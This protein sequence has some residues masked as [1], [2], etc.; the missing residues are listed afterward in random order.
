MMNLN[1]EAPERQDIEALLP[2]HAAGTLSRRDSDRVEQALA[3]DRELARRYELVR[4]ELNETIH[5]NE[6]LGAPSARAMERLFSAIDAEAPV[7]KKASFNFT[8]RVV[9]FMS[10]F[11][12]RTLAYAGTAAALALVVQAAVLTTVVVRN[13]DTPAS[14]TLASDPALSNQRAVVRF[15]AN[16]T[17]AEVTRFLDVN[18]AAVV[19]GPNRG[20][21]YE[22]Q[23]AASPMSDNDFNSAI[24][25][26]RAET[27]I[28]AFIAPKN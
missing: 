21:M 3:G 14:H 23:L 6:T 5:L 12:P 4:E 19:Q 20:G 13:Q 28:V 24:R 26:M 27:N 25:R 7:A 17:L 10:S 1:R 22:L 15:T 2:W 9:E 18:K 11:S 16:A 8:A